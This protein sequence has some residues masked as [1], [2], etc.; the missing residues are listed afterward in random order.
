MKK[1]KFQKLHIL[2]QKN[3]MKKMKKK[4]ICLNVNTTECKGG[5]EVNCKEFNKM[6]KI[7]ESYISMILVFQML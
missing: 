1:G 2:K 4:L 7:S 5:R 6:Y 3:V